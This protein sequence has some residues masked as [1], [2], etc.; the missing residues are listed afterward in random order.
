MQP[1]NPDNRKHLLGTFII[2]EGRGTHYLTLRPQTQLSICR[3]ASIAHLFLR[4]AVISLNPLPRPAPA[5][6]L[7]PRML[8]SVHLEKA[9]D[10]SV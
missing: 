7:L 1:F 2:L 9:E 4:E 3:S 10:S 8:S 6:I 5:Q